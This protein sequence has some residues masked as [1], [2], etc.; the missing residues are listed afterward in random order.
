[1]IWIFLVPIALLLM[2]LAD[3]PAG[4]YTLVRIAMCLVSCFSCYWSYKS[5][6]KIGIA[7]V[8]YALLAL[9][10]NPIIPIYLHD[11]DAWA[12]IDIASAILLA[13]RYLTLKKTIG[14]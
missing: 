9:L 13:L 5:D 11:K 8:I 3:L 12:V 14:Q 10:F 1:M 7:T 2:G 6:D 4:Y